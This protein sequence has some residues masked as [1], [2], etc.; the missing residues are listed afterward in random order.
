[1]PYG[2][3]TNGLPVGVQ[4]L[5]PMLGEPVMYRVAAVLESVA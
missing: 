2:T 3:G 1:V 4:I 5:A